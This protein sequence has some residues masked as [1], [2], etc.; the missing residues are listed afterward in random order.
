MGCSMGMTGVAIVLATFA[1]CFFSASVGLQHRAVRAENPSETVEHQAVGLGPRALGRVMRSRRWMT[2]TLLAVIGS[3]LH[4]TALSL[5][6]LAVV[7]PIGVLSLVLTVLFAARAG[8]VTVTPQVRAAVVSVCAGVGGFV[9]VAAMAGTSPAA[10]RPAGV[11]IVVVGALALAAAGLHTRGR[12]RCLALAAAAA[13]LFGLGSALIR[14]ASGDI[15]GGSAVAVGIG[16]AVESVLLMLTGGW[17]M[18]QAYAAGPS[19]VVV[20]ATTV[21]DPLTAVAVGLGVYGEAAK[22]NPVTGFTQVG[23]ALLAVAG[24][25]VLARSVPDQRDLE[26]EQGMRK[27]RPHGS[28]A[29]RILLS[30]DT[31]PPDVNGA[32]FFA[33]RLARGLAGRG[34]DVHVVCPAT[35]SSP[36]TESDGEITVHRI[37]SIRTPFHPTFRVCAPWYAA[38]AVPVLLDRLQPDIVHAQSHFS[39]GRAMIRSATDRGLPTIATNHFMPE[40]LLG[41]APVPRALR[42]PLARWAWRDLVRVYR[43]AHVVTAPTPRAVRLLEVNGLPG[44]PRAVSCGI[45]IG[46]YA[47]NRDQTSTKATSV[48]FVGRLDAEKNI[49]ELIRAVAQLPDVHAEIVGDGTYR[50]RLVALADSLGVG[51]RVRFHGFVSDEELVRAYRRCDIFCMPGTAELQSLATMEAMAAGLP[52]VAADAMALPHLVHPG[53][54]G[55]LYTPGDVDGLRAGIAGLAHDPVARAAMGRESRQIIAGHDIEH[56]L[57]V[58]EGVYRDAA[59]ILSPPAESEALAS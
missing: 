16:L 3:M 25:I 38:R 40:N 45:D 19:A 4:V 1:A 18:Q 54:N 34:H 48:L 13:V 35:T 36:G 14:A 39:I 2:G 10:V 22:S 21:L 57:D 47:A 37:K 5:A 17:L 59:G 56:T 32:A 51:D 23:L 27:T 11:Q 7:Q 33:D 8:R 29:L 52:V 26:E 6:P 31:F 46:H 43:L 9:V 55:F 30:A 42:A 24:V 28:T 53:V 49:D 50:D 44:S 15:L 41:Y 20:A 12:A 58:F